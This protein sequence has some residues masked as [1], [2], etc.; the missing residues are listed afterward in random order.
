M[1]DRL[2]EQL[3]L[4]RGVIDNSP[5]LT[6]ESREEFEKE[7][8]E[9]TLSLGEKPSSSLE[10]KVSLVETK[11]AADEVEA[12]LVTIHHL[13]PASPRL[14]EVRRIATQMREG[15]LSPDQGRRELHKLMQ[16]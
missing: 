15:E 12:V 9:L 10:Q 3:K 13:N 1:K 11:V 8:A 4:L 14:V 6:R 2:K 7:I 5:Y 16:S